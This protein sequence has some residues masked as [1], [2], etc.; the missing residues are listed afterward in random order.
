MNFYNLFGN[1][2]KFTNYLQLKSRSLILSLSSIKIVI[3][4]LL[5]YF[6]LTNKNVEIKF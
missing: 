6:T 5:Y 3:F 2:N 1:K 4:M